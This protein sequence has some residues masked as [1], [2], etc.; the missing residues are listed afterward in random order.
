[1][2]LPALGTAY[3][4]TLNQAIAPASVSIGSSATLRMQAGSGFTAE[5]PMTIDGGGAVRGAG[6]I[7]L[8]ISN[9]GT[10][11]ADGSFGREIV[12]YANITNSGRI[13]VSH[14]GVIHAVT[15]PLF[16]NSG[17]IVGKEGGGGI[18]IM[19]GYTGTLSNQ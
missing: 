7:T 14:G 16:R 1:A 5:G 6:E 9:R 11:E 3:V 2:A 8:R 15:G 13:E 10:L 17:S 12:T 4:V 18:N 19:D